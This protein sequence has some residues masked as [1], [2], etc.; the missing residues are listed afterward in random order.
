MLDD[1]GRAEQIQLSGRSLTMHADMI[2]WEA[3]AGLRCLTVLD[4]SSNALRGKRKRERER[5]S[6]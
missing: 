5:E 1:R 2:D 6:S 4:L 3:L